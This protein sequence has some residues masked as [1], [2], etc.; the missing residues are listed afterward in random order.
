MTRTLR[1]FAVVTALGFVFRVVAQVKQ[2]VEGFVGF[3]PHV[4]AAPAVAAGR[5]AARHKLFAPE[6]RDAVAAAAAAYLNFCAIY[7]QSK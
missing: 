3:N 4:A 5:S 2:G 1:A 7:K 6:S